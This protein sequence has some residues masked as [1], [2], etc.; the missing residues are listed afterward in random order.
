M[1]KMVESCSNCKYAR[2]FEEKRAGECRINPPSA[3]GSRNGYPFPKISRDGWCGRW[4]KTIDDKT[5][6]DDIIVV[7]N[8]YVISSLYKRLED[9][10]VYYKDDIIKIVTEVMG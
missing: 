10:T 7:S 4:G 1:N 6:G 8:K 2:F 9:E 3:S 5:T